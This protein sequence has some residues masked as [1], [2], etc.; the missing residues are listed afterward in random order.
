MALGLY[1][2]VLA[3]LYWFL[4]PLAITFTFLEAGVLLAGATLIRE[5][6]RSRYIVGVS[7]LLFASPHLLVVTAPRINES[8]VIALVDYFAHGFWAAAFIWMILQ[9]FPVKANRFGLA[10]RPLVAALMLIGFA[11]LNAATVQ[12]GRHRDRV[13]QAWT[14]IPLGS[15]AQHVA[16]VAVAQSLETPES[17]V[18]RD[19]EYWVAPPLIGV[20]GWQGTFT[21]RE[22][23]VVETDYGP[24]VLD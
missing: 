22:G 16:E 13:V 17:G 14:A 20:T 8:S 12:L 1:I 6:V 9:V 2:E 4:R 10:L 24:L 21:L 19:G 23:V 5:H 11:R 18:P 3:L 7:A 15:T